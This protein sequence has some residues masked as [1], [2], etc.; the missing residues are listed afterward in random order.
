MLKEIQHLLNLF[1]I[2]HAPASEPRIAIICQENVLITKVI[3]ATY[4][5]YC[6]QLFLPT[7]SRQFYP[8]NRKAT[9]H[10]LI[11]LLLIILKLMKTGIL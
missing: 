10:L 6:R 5:D 8:D 2:Y 4:I 3:V 1:I 9:D 7:Y 11:L